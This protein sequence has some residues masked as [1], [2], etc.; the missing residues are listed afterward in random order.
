MADNHARRTWTEPEYRLTVAHEV[1]DTAVSFHLLGEEIHA[2]R[3]VR[4]TCATEGDTA[5]IARYASHLSAASAEVHT[6]I[7]APVHIRETWV[8]LLPDEGPCVA[9]YAVYEAGGGDVAGGVC[10]EHA[11]CVGRYDAP[12]WLFHVL[13]D[14]S[15]GG[16]YGDLR[17]ATL[18]DVM[19]QTIVHTETHTELHEREGMPMEGRPLTQLAGAED[20]AEAADELV[21]AALRWGTLPPELAATLSLG[22]L[23]GAS[24]AW[25]SAE[26]DEYTRDTLDTSTLRLALQCR[27]L[28][29]G[30]RLVLDLVDEGIDREGIADAVARA[31]DMLELPANADQE[32]PPKLTRLLFASWFAPPEAPL[33]EVLTNRTPGVPINGTANRGIVAPSLVDLGWARKLLFD[34]S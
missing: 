17:T 13:S 7:S 30:V 18:C 6:A 9:L 24:Y 26:L 12:R 8:V 2:S 29:R 34:R 21:S 33:D 25:R 14:V 28:G 19:H 15:S 10:L 16:R 27:L 32:E 22:P 5:D 4:L 1:I 31:R 20:L 11:W 3:R 23:E